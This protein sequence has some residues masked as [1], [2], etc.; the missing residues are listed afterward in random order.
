MINNILL[1]DDNDDDL[2]MIEES[3]RDAGFTGEIIKAKSGEEGVE[4]VKEHKPDIAI[5]DTN[6]P[7]MDGFETC[8]RIKETAGGA[9]K[10]VIMTGLIEAVS[11]TK[12]REA[13]SDDYCVKTKG[14]TEI[15]KVLKGLG[16]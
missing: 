1:I 15:I 13:N 8:R 4:K 10:I 6:L 2:I 3:L 7:Q 14:A 12:A 9:V 11:V 16:L 5:V